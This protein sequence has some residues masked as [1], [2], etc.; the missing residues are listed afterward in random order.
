MTIGQFYREY[1]PLPDDK[2][3]EN[4]RQKRLQEKL[5]RLKE[6]GSRATSDTSTG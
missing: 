2:I 5:K 3:E 4:T 1:W 6:N